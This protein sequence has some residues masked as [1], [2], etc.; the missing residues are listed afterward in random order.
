MVLIFI[1]VLSFSGGINIVQ[2]QFLPLPDLDGV[3]LIFSSQLNEGCV[4]FTDLQN[5]S[6]F[7][8]CQILLL[9]A[10]YDAF[11]NGKVVYDQFNT[12]RGSVL[13]IYLRN[14]EIIG[15]LRIISSDYSRIYLRPN[16]LA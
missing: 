3:G 2:E 7:E 5:D 13:E 15:L 9:R 12:T 6:S 14:Q 4:L 10:S 8:E 11:R 1:A 16:S